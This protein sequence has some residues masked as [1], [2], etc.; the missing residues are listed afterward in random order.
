MFFYISV[1]M[2]EADNPFGQQA[3][4]LEIDPTL[5]AELLS[6]ADLRSIIPQEAIDGVE[7]DL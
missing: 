2:Y 3:A 4:A 5:L 6:D 1:F 7:A